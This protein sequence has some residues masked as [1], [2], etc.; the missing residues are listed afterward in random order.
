MRWILRR[1]NKTHY[2]T[3][4]LPFVEKRLNLIE[5]AP[6]GTGKSYLFGRVSRFGALPTDSKI[7]RATLFYNKTR[8]TE[9]LVATVTCC[10]RRNSDNSIR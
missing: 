9:G 1:G 7:S 5:L 4:L 2:D 3:R 6:K 10:P 8:H